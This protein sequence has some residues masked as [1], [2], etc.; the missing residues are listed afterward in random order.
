MHLVFGP[1]SSAFA[2][3]IAL[4]VGIAVM[5]AVSLNIVNGFAGQFSIGHAGFMAVGAFL[6]AS[7]TYYGGLLLFGTAVKQAGP[8]YALSLLW[9]SEVSVILPA[10][11]AGEWLLPAGCLAGGIVAAGLGWVV[12]LP[13]LRLRG[14]YLAIV[15]LGFGEIVRVLLQQT[16]QQPTALNDFDGDALAKGAIDWLKLALVLGLSIAWVFG[17]RAALSPARRRQSPR[18][19]Q[20]LSVGGVV[21]LWIGYF[22]W[23]YPD[24][25]PSL[26]VLPLGGALGFSGLPTYASLFWVALFAALTCVAAFRL[27]RSSTGRAFLSV[28][29]DEIAARAMGIDITRI[30]V[31]AFVL[32]AFFAG[33][34]GGLYAHT[35]VIL[36]PKEAGFLRSFEIVIMVVLGGLGSISGVVLAAAILTILPELLRAPQAAFAAWP[37]LLP[38]V[39]VLLALGFV[40]RALEGNTPRR[41][42]RFVFI[43]ALAGV[44]TLL[45]GVFGIGANALLRALSG[46]DTANLGEYR[47]IIYALLLIGMMLLRPQGL[48][49]VSEIWD[50]PPRRTRKP[51]PKG[52]AA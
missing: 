7:V 45:I 48:F 18:S 40:L 10:L 42:A 37:W 39:G 47:M 41:L 8:T 25:L 50:P 14:D 2:S 44:G 9:L 17:L 1:L 5:L 52:A 15:T 22:W 13:S 30:K 38:T 27:K 6:A 16:G 36:A 20:A 34:A 43:F 12:G 11:T 21:A 4:D 33:L 23:T 35:G 26:S 51:A 32:A 24:A 31:R 49:G 29:E 19:T 46:K 3:K 28:R